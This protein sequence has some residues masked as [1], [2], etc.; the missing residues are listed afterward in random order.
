M[1]YSCT[2]PFVQLFRNWANNI[3]GPNDFPKGTLYVPP[4]HEEMRDCEH[5]VGFWTIAN[6]LKYLE[7]DIK[8]W[9]Y[10]ENKN[11]SKER[12]TPSEYFN[13]GSSF[14]SSSIIGM[15]TSLSPKSL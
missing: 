10:F 14:T 9:E 13:V 7:E 5:H 8:R 4:N 3:V 11:T 6:Y 1:F 15:C 12:L 2:I